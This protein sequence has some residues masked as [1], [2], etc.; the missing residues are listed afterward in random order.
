M[1]AT[2]ALRFLR[3]EPLDLVEANWEASNSLAETG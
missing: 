3:V 2:D 1:P